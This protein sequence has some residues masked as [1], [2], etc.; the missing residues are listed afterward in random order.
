MVYNRSS[1]PMGLLTPRYYSLQD[2]PN[3]LWQLLG[4]RLESL[5]LTALTFTKETTYQNWGI[6][7]IAVDSQKTSA[8]P[9]PL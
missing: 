3:I 8:G 1:Y 6:L 7:K 5:S 9:R 2:I 4:V